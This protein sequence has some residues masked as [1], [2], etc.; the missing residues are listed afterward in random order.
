MMENYVLYSASFSKVNSHSLDN[1]ICIISWN[2]VKLSVTTQVVTAIIFDDYKISSYLTENSLSRHHERKINSTI[3]LKSPM[4]HLIAWYVNRTVKS[5][6]Y[7]STLFNNIQSVKEKQHNSAIINNY[8]FHSLPSSNLK[9]Q[10]ILRM[11]IAH[12]SL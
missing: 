2:L 10:K 5:K 4:N 6:L 12:S 1:F 8:D 7:S 11:L 3:S 9:Y